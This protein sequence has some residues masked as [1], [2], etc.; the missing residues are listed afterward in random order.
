MR[1]DKFK[2]NLLFWLENVKENA[3]IQETEE[4]LHVE[5]GLENELELNVNGKLRTYHLF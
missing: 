3:E 4:S 1:F 5:N 2:F